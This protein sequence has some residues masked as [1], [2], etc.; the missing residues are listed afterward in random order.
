MTEEGLDISIVLPCYNGEQYL[1]EVLASIYQQ[2]TGLRYEV[3][4][5]DSGSTDRTVEI[6]STHPVRLYKIAKSEFGHGKTR[7]LGARVARGR[8]IVFLTQ[9]ATPANECWLEN[10][11]MPFSEDLR[12]AGV[13][14]RQIPRSDCNPCEWR[15]I[16]RGASPV[17][18]VKRVNFDDDL[19]KKN[20]DKHMWMIIAFSNVSS[21]IR[22]EVLNLLPF[23]E[24]VVMVE[25]QEWSKRAIE[26]GWTVRYEASSSVYHSHNHASRAL[27]RRHF[28]Y[29]VSYQEF[30]HFELSFGKVLVYAIYN[31]LMDAKFIF[32]QSQ[33]I[34]WKLRWLAKCPI[35]RFVMQ[36]GLYRGL[37]ATNHARVVK[38]PEVM[39]NQTQS[40]ARR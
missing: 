11:V 24:T 25:D 31:S 33:G 28:D 4:I 16:D 3:I 12:V 8:Y 2:R 17:S 6:A 7:N 34:V 38:T 15:D 39:P 29:G 22:K 35:I 19:Q 14:S 36:Y 5:I 40:N 1:S 21:C 27:Y 26:A 18:L 30:L 10:L 32:S 37:R 13:Y 20:Y 23:S 9:D